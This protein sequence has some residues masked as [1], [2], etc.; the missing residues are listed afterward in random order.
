METI[1][2]EIKSLL[3]FQLNLVEFPELS[4]PIK[5]VQK[6]IDVLRGRFP[7]VI[8]Y[9]SRQKILSQLKSYRIV[10]KS[11]K[12]T[13]LKRL[14]HIFRIWLQK[15]KAKRLILVVI[16][17]LILPFTPILA[18]LPGPNVF[19]YVPALLFYFHFRSYMGLRKVDVE[20]LQIEI[21]AAPKRKQAHPA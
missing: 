4:S 15:E 9:L 20:E 1:T 8:Q 2:F 11:R 12:R 17:A 7:R 10:F 6:G 21:I 3:R 13:S 19:F 18:L 5:W 14:K 16:E